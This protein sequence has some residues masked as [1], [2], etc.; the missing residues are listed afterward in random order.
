[1]D[2]TVD[3]PD[4]LRAKRKRPQ[5][6]PAPGVG[7]DGWLVLFG[8][9]R[10]YWGS[11]NEPPRENCYDFRRA[12]HPCRD[13]DTDRLCSAALRVVLQGDGLWRNNAGSRQARRN[14]FSTAK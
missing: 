2:M 6:G 1:M 8:F 13:D 9:A 4:D 14:L 10:P 3:N 11:L 5:P 7:R 12:L